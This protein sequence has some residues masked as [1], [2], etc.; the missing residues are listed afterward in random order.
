MDSALVP[1][2]TSNREKLIPLPHSPT[3]ISRFECGGRIL[4]SLTVHEH[5]PELP[6]G[7]K[8]LGALAKPPQGGV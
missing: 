3:W 4:P 6:A 5:V 8:V 1:A 2:F 7:P